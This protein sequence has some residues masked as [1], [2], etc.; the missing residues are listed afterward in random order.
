LELAEEKQGFVD[1]ETTV[2]AARFL[3]NSFGQGLQVTQVQLAA[4]YGVLINGGRYIK[5]S[6]VS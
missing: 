5:P 1:N 4:A 6:I 3:N 2:S